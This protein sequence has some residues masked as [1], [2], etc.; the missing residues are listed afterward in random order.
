MLKTLL[1]STQS[2][3]SYFVSVFMKVSQ[4]LSCEEMMMFD[5][6]DHIQAGKGSLTFKEMN[7][8]KDWSLVMDPSEDKLLTEYEIIN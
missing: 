4:N 3:T 2:L 6:N 1:K 7:D 5:L 8:L